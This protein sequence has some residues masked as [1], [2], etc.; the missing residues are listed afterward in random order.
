MYSPLLQAEVREDTLLPCYVFHGDETFPADQFVA[1]VR[2]MLAEAVGGDISV[3]R[4]Y[5]EES[6][7][8]DIIDT[9]RTAPFLFQH[10][11]LLVVRMPER[12]AGS[13]RAPRRTG[14][15]ASGEKGPRFLNASD[16]RIIRDYCASPSAGTTLVVIMAGRLKK[17]DAAV[18]FFSSLP[19]AAV[20]VKEIRA[21][22]PDNVKKWADRKAQSLGKP[23]TEAAKNRLYEIVGS[24]LRLLDNEIEKLALFVGDKRRI[25]EE[26]VDQAT[27]WVRS[28]EAYELDDALMAA[29]CGKALAVLNNLFAEGERP[30]QIVGRLAGFFRNLLEAQTRL[31]EKKAGRDEIF[32]SL[33]PY[34]QKT[35]YG[36][37][38]SKFKEFFATVDGLAPADLNRVLKDLAQADMR[39]KTTDSSPKIVLEAFLEGY[40]MVRK[41]PASTFRR[42][43][44]S[45]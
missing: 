31:R 16:Q 36:L 40:C 5:I 32:Q 8:M 4:F 13:D 1:Q 12:K 42:P 23:L 22:Y 10:R 21:L 35:H 20:L 43:G 39:I 3:A 28:F 38:G 29:D 30:E 45:G 34:I 33:F 26:D 15:G 41:R 24:D 18:R 17:S 11:R 6:R 2:Q 25:D 19:K 44:P 37:Y 14:S 7:W 27:A 9:A